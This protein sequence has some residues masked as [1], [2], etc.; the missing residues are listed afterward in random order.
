MTIKHAIKFYILWHTGYL[1]AMELVP[2]ISAL[3]S[4]YLNI[5]VHMGLGKPKQVAS[6][7][8][9]LA[10][11]RPT[12]AP[13]LKPAEHLRQLSATIERIKSDRRHTYIEAYEAA[14]AHIGDAAVLSRIEKLAE[15]RRQAEYTYLDAQLKKSISHFSEFTHAPDI[16][17]AKAS[18]YRAAEKL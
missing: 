11:L 9:Q 18:E 16:D 6:A 15:Q 2:E 5:E 1:S 14:M 7:A 10:A 4:Y 13:G 3:E 17:S 12:L 8:E